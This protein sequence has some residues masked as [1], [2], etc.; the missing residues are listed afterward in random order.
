MSY[1]RKESTMRAFLIYLTLLFAG[2][3]PSF[4]QNDS[5]FDPISE[6]YVSVKHD[7]TDF[8]QAL[9][10]PDDVQSL[11]ISLEK[12]TPQDLKKLERFK[13]LTHLTLKYC[14]IKQF[15]ESILECSQLRY[16]NLS[17]NDF[18]SIPEGISS[19]SLLEELHLENTSITSLPESVYSLPL[20]TLN[21]APKYSTCHI[22]E[23]LLNLDSLTTLNCHASEEDFQQ[24]VL[25][26][27]G[28]EV[29]TIH[30]DSMYSPCGITEIPNL[31]E[32]NMVLGLRTF[33]EPF[34]C[35]FTELPALSQFCIIHEDCCWPYI[36]VEKEEIDRI[37]ALL[38]ESCQLRGF[39]VRPE[40]IELR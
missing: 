9:K 3:M 19:L 6:K 13:N 16:L 32:F 37:K 28:L 14:Q 5:I 20:K 4:A 24:I 11:T 23:G 21:V 2:A 38:P 8:K 29:L 39:A 12:L 33:Y 25:K 26:M 27:K 7:Y 36:N 10:N 17:N 30:V 18:S 1:L 40:S 31:K 15:P 22:S 34:D 35:S